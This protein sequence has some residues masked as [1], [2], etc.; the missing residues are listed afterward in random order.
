LATA[1]KSKKID[2]ATTGN[3][4]Q[5]QAEPELRTSIGIGENVHYDFE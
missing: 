1:G 4:W 2:T 3:F 5:H